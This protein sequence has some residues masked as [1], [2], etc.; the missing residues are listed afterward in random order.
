MKL[1]SLALAGAAVL[2]MSAPEAAGAQGVV[3]VPKFRSIEL[4]GGG[5]V[6][7]RHGPVQRVRVLEGD[8]RVSDVRVKPAERRRVGGNTYTSNPDQLVIDVCRQ[9]CDGNYNLVVEVVT[10]SIEAIAVKGGGQIEA[11]GRFPRQ[12]NIGIAVHGGGEIDARALPASNVGAAVSDG[13]T[14]LTRAEGSLGAAIQDGG[15]IR[16]WGDPVVGTAIDGG[17]TVTRGE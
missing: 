7:L 11:A 16:Y 10:P 9:S 8:I 3:Q 15:T 14:I 6:L 13:G 12:G 5:R 2:F 4:N 17:G 1:I